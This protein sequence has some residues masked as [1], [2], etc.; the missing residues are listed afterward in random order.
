MLLDIAKCSQKD[1]SVSS[2]VQLWIVSLQAG[3]LVLSP[4]EFTKIQ[5]SEKQNEYL[6]L[7]SHNFKFCVQYYLSG[8]IKNTG[9]DQSKLARYL[10]ICL[11][12]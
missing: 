9:W 6:Q 11:T 5:Y 2:G 8:T 12:H 7:P 1:S 4:G 10:I 3:A